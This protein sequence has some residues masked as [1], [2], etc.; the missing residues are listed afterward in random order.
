[1]EVPV[2][3]VVADDVAVALECTGAG[4][5]LERVV[6]L[7][8][9][10]LVAQLPQFRDD[11][12]G[13]G[14]DVHRRESLPDLRLRTVR[15]DGF[16]PDRQRCGDPLSLAD[17]RDRLLGTGLVEVHR[18]AV[19]FDDQR[20]RLAS[21]GRQAVHFRFRGPVDRAPVADAPPRLEPPQRERVLLAF[22]PDVAQSSER[23]EVFVDGTL[24]DAGLLCDGRDAHPTGPVQRVDDTEGRIDRVDVVVRRRHTPLYSTE[25]Y[26][27]SRHPRKVFTA[28]RR[29]AIDGPTR[30]PRTAGDDPSAGEAMSGSF[31]TSLSLDGEWAFVTDPESVGTDRGWERP[32]AQWP[33]RV[34]TVS[35]PMAWEELDAYRDYTGT[36]WYRR[37]VTV[38]ESDLDGRDALLRFGAVDYGTD[39]WVN[40]EHVGHNEGGYLP[41]EFDA[42]DAL[43]AGEN[44]VVVRVTD[45]ADLSEIPHGKQGDPWYTRV[46]GIWQSVTLRLCPPTRVERVEATPDCQADTA[47]VDVAVRAGPA[48]RAALSC[49]VAARR[50]GETVATDRIDPDAGVPATLDFADPDYWSP[51]D[52]ALYDLQVTLLDGETVVDRSEDYFGMREFDTDGDRFLLNG[53]PITMRGVLEQGYYPETLYRPPDEDT[54]EAEIAAAADLGFN[55]IR[56]HIKPAHPDFLEAADRQGMLVWEE[57]A[58]P[59]R[60]TEDSRAAMDEQLWG[61]IDRDYN[62][63]SVVVWGLY[64]EEWGIGHYDEE[65]DLWSDEAKQRYL[66]DLVRE[67][68]ERDPTRLVC[69][70][71]G[72]AHVDTDVNDFHRYFVSPDRA[73]AWAGDLDHICHHPGDNYA[74]REFDDTG[75]PIVMSELGTWGLGDVGALR[76]RYDGDPPWFDHDFLEPLKRPAGLDERFA[77]TDLPAAFG[78][79]DGLA[80]AWQR[81]EYVSVKH[82]LEQLRRREGVAG[83]V[84]TEL[85]DVEWEFN[86]ILDYLREPKSFY[87]EFARVNAPVSVVADLD[88]H[89]VRPGETVDVDATVVNDTARDL[90]G[91]VE[92]SL[93]GASGSEHLEAPAHAPTPLPETVAVEA[94]T[95]T[96]TAH[97]ELTVRFDTGETTVETTEP[98]TVVGPD[99]ADP[100]D[101]TVY[102]TG[103][104]ASRLAGAGV[105]VTHELGVADVA[106]VDR[107]TPEAERFAAR[108][109][110]VVQIP[111]TDGRMA[112]RGPFSYRGVPEQESWVGAASFF[113]QDS[114][115]FAGLSTSRRLGWELDG[116][117]PYAVASDVDADADEIHAGYLEGWLANWGSPLVVRDYDAGSVAALTFRVR[118][119]YGT[120]PVATALVDRLIGTLADR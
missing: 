53:D 118:E 108:G 18:L 88:T 110:A 58:N 1:M 12:I 72:W 60:F 43:D 6:A 65:T 25:P 105:A 20:R 116:V 69:D 63:P 15:V 115:L 48:D 13:L 73:S 19:L 57:L 103:G 92:W 90:R 98:V 2:R 47:S 62:R 27:C 93:A 5:A 35:V 81:R 21:A 109:G 67:V 41:F 36:A 84:L 78:G 117:Y 23:I 80:A 44:A 102:A 9:E 3:F 113:Y 52:P 77:A 79:L 70:N 42:T 76:E 28:R 106:F 11:P 74:T 86:G 112:D 91:T 7:D 51:A 87:D 83:Y 54:F 38:A 100:P 59:T 39:V 46:S 4:R 37:T 71:S 30:R 29:M 99:A 31:R 45:P 17:R 16:P 68:R 82:V 94:P 32:G 101:A 14:V 40:G 119:T 111:A 89:A 55:L 75:G 97:P 26:M 64:N 107:V 114:P 50:D 104:F 34:R 33:D 95:D 56:K 10:A 85:S 22:L 120:Q 24:R 96:G 66:A 8:H 49:R 61:M